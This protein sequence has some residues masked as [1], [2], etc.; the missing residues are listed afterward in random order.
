MRTLQSFSRILSTSKHFLGAIFRGY[1]DYLYFPFDANQPLPEYSIH[2]LDQVISVL[3]DL[4]IIY[5]VTDGTILGLHRDGRLIPHDNDL[6]IALVD[7]PDLLP[8]FKRLTR[9][10]WKIGRVLVRGVHVYQLIFYK[11]E[12]VLDFCNWKKSGPHVYFK[13]PEVVGYRK[14][15]SEYYIPHSLIT[16]DRILSTHSNL[17]SWLEM[18]YGQDWNV[19]K[20]SKG[21]WRSDTNDIFEAI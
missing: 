6:D 16:P 10:G 8:L 7:S 18:H 21:D 13:C 2:Y 12:V 20:S 4:R 17:I 5:F 14:Q 9:L 3:D 11:D 19:P 15:S 1:F